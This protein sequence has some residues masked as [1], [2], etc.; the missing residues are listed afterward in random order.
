MKILQCLSLLF[1]FLAFLSCDTEMQGVMKPVEEAIIE[2]VMADPMTE[3]EY[4]DLP[5]IDTLEL[6]PG[7]YRMSVLFGDIYENQVTMIGTQSMPENEDVFVAVFLY[8][9]VEDVGF[10]SFFDADVVV[11][12]Y[13]KDIAPPLI[14]DTGATYHIYHGSVVNVS[15]KTENSEITYAYEPPSGADLP[16]LQTAFAEGSLEP[17]RY[18]MFTD[19]YESDP[20]TYRLTELS[21]LTAEENVLISVV[22]EKQPSLYKKDDTSI[23]SRSSAFIVDIG[24]PL[25]FRTH[26][27]AGWTHSHHDY[28]G[29]AVDIFGDPG[30]LVYEEDAIE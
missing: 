20:E 13:A 10:D 18:L 8:P 3:P 30:I 26:T 25:G 16:V 24:E 1:I 19:G 22:L 17:G 14:D 9:L 12:I 21:C 11:R 4:S 6:E 15:K 29:V 23:F 7:L 27:A 2:E 28:S 5:F